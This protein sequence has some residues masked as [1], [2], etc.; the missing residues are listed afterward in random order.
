MIPRV[1]TFIITTED[2]SKHYVSAPTK[3]LAK[4][5][6]RHAGNYDGIKRIG[7]ARKGK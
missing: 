2:G 6:L 5:N 7:V 3:L 1:K 4:L